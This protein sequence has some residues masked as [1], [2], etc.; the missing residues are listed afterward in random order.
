MLWTHGEA[1]AKEAKT[2]IEEQTKGSDREPRTEVR[3]APRFWIAEDYHQKYYLRADR[4]LVAALL[5]SAWTDEALRGST[6]AARVNGW[7]RGHGTE[8]EIASEVESLG[9]GE[10]ARR[11]LAAALGKRMPA[12]A[13]GG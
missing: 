9:L 12:P 7:I 8:K 11:A 6:L 13:A 2:F 1:Q 5:G 4:K 3:E 10:K